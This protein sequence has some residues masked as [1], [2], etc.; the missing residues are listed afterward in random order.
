[1][2]RLR[3]E[4]ESKPSSRPIDYNDGILFLGSCFSTHVGDWLFDSGMA[5]CVNILG[6]LYNPASIAYALD[7][8]R[9]GRRYE[10]RRDMADGIIAW[11][12]ATRRYVSFDHHGRFSNASAEALCQQLNDAAERAESFLA[13]HRYIAI[14]FGTAWAYEQ[15]ANGRIVANCHKFPGTEFRR[16]CMTVNEIADTWV[17]LIDQLPDHHFLFT[18]SPIRHV[19]D[20]LH[21]NQLSKATLLLA[22]DEIIARR[23]E[24]AEYVAAYEILIDDLRDY[25]FYADDLVHPS[26][27]AIRVVGEYFIKNFFTD[28]ARAYIAE[29][30]GLIKAMMH[31]PAQPEVEPYRTFLRRNLEA[32]E[33]LLKKYPT[34]RLAEIRDDIRDRLIYGNDDVKHV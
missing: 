17:T 29:V 1:M 12:D 16:R 14:T 20:T 31:S 11:S 27:T 13:K 21:G 28:S 33:Q 8:L 3:T 25:R 22:V 7:G 23:P 18:V 9:C 26:P 32:A 24:R 15:R 19:G 34:A 6:T 5:V 2:I 30:S 10:A 4:I